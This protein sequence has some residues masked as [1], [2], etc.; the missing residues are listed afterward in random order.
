[1]QL[2]IS[3]CVAKERL[4]LALAWGGTCRVQEKQNVPKLPDARLWIYNCVMVY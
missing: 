1:M 4:G 2:R 3:N